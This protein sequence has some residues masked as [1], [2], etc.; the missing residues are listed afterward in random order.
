MDLPP[1]EWRFADL[2]VRMQVL[3]GTQRYPRGSISRPV[4]SELTA[5][6]IA[7]ADV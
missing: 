2:S 4:N 1:G 6:L 3:K 7:V 5:A